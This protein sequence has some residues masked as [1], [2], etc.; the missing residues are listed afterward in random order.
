MKMPRSENEPDFDELINA[1]IRALGLY[2]DRRIELGVN[3]A[4]FMTALATLAGQ[5]SVQYAEQPPV[6]SVMEEVTK[7]SKFVL[8]AAIDFANLSAEERMQS[9]IEART[10]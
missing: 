8:R 10:H 2:M 4:V 6:T 1:E 3:F 9:V 7:F 5:M